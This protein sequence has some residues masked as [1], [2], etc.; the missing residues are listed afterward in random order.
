MVQ[1]DDGIRALGEALAQIKAAADAAQNT[2]RVADCEA[3][4]YFSSPSESTP[5]VEISIVNRSKGPVTLYWLNQQRQRI[6]YAT[7]Q[8]YS[9]VTQPSH[10]GHLWIVTSSDDRCVAFFVAGNAPVQSVAIE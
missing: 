2:Y 5:A 1:A 4:K 7:I 9:S 10:A 8:A 6:F 3:A